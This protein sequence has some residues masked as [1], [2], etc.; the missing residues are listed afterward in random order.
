[1][2]IRSMPSG[3]FAILFS[4]FGVHAAGARETLVNKTAKDYGITAEEAEQNAKAQLLKDAIIEKFGEKAFEE[5]KEALEREIMGHPDGYLSNVVRTE[6]MQV[7]PDRKFRVTVNAQLRV[8]TLVR[9]VRLIIGE[10]EPPPFDP[11]GPPPDEVDATGIGADEDAA[12]RDARRNAVG[13]V[14]GWLASFEQRNA[15]DEL[16][17]DEIL[18]HADELV[19]SHRQLEKPR[20]VGDRMEVRIAAAVNQDGVGERLRSAGIMPI[21]SLR[22]RSA[23]QSLRRTL[24]DFNFPMGLF[25]AKSTQA[26][27]YQDGK[28]M[29][30][31]D[32]YVDMEK[33]SAFAKAMG[34][35][36][37][38]I[39]A[40]K[41]TKVLRYMHKPKDDIGVPPELL[42]PEKLYL[43][44]V[45]ND[46]DSYLDFI[47][48]DRSWFVLCE[49]YN[50]SKKGAYSFNWAGYQIA[51]NIH[52]RLIEEFFWPFADNHPNRLKQ[53]ARVECKD[54]YGET[55]YRSAA[56]EL[57]ATIT[58]AKYDIAEY[59]DIE[60]KAK[61]KTIFLFPAMKWEPW[62]PLYGSRNTTILGALIF[63]WDNDKRE[64]N[65]VC[66]PVP[67]FSINSEIEMPEGDFLKLKTMEFV[68]F[69]HAAASVNQAPSER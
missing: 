34:K 32:V 61:D 29:V 11:P 69:A 58:V 4:V 47:W 57:R 67:S 5:H 36:M 12:L 50:S 16:I 55:L 52:T 66:I 21:H 27:Y 51:E 35:T 24:A 33:Y 31:F 44:P 68:F 18:A 46:K 39:N 38:E 19:R 8:D 3:F 30:K 10:P 49:S 65:Q 59:D 6:Q 62:K 7:L 60:K 54:E 23:Y 26:P 45:A 22:D 20:P 40:P 13:R 28:A 37:A 53:Y 63:N 14:V 9:R 17:R 56:G 42:P 2:G 15:N 64:N 25:G 41:K 48:N 1:M 43:E